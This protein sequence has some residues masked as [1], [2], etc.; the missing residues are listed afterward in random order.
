MGYRCVREDVFVPYCYIY[1]N[2]TSCEI[3][4]NG[5]SFFQNYCLLTTHIQGILN[6]STTLEATIAKIK[7][8]I[9]IPSKTTTTST[10]T[11]TTTTTIIITNQTN[12]NTNTN[13]N[14][15]ANA[16]TNTVR[17]SVAP[18]PNCANQNNGLCLA[19][20]PGFVVSNNTCQQMD[21]NCGSYELTSGK[22]VSCIPNF[23]FGPNGACIPVQAPA[24]ID[25]C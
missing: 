7:S 23:Q 6:G 21:P 19:C 13:T 9:G 24:K 14:A 2:E 1:Y 17:P 15:N 16:N 12:T 4:K 18:I 20:N 8:E 10:T 22:C 5:Y 3:C 25:N 11:S